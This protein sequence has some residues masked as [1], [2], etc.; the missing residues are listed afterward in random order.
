MS[1]K[2]SGLFTRLK[3]S[4]NGVCRDGLVVEKEE[5]EDVVVK[6]KKS[7][8]NTSGMC[9]TAEWWDSTTRVKTSAPHN[10]CTALRCAN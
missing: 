3:R 6:K 8:G 5:E 1:E 9:K 2:R 10:K 7:V 4:Y